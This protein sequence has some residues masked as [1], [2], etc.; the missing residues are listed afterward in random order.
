MIFC[1]ITKMTEAYLDSFLGHQGFQL[2]RFIIN[3]I[4][5]KKKWEKK[6]VICLVVRDL[7]QGFSFL[8]LHNI[9]FCPNLLPFCIAQQFKAIISSS[10]CENLEPFSPLHLLSTCHLFWSPCSTPGILF[11]KS[12]LFSAQVR[13]PKVGATCARASLKSGQTCSK[14]SAPRMATLK[15]NTWLDA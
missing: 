12:P 3:L 6:E 4:L 8:F 15:D 13:L 11:S 9:N 5:W 10:S 14:F 2:N 7:N 1:S